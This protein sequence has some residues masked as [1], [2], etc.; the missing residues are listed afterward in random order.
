M[1]RKWILLAAAIAFLAGCSDNKE[2]VNEHE[3]KQIND[4]SKEEKEVFPY[5]APLTGIGFKE[6]P[7]GRAYAVMINNDPKARP[8]SGLHKADIV[9]ELLAEGNVTR[10][11]AVFQSEEADRI[12][13]VRS[14]RDY[15]IELAK[16]YDAL[17]IAH[18]YSPE[19]KKMLDKGYIDHIN[20][21]QYD[22]S[23]FKRDKSRV[24]PHNS[25]IT[26]EAVLK[27]ADKIGIDMDNTPSTL[28]FLSEKEAEE[29]DGEQANSVLISY[30][31]SNLF[32]VI[33]EYDEGT[34]KYKRYSNDELTADL[35]S[36]EPVLLD[37]IF[38]VETHHEIIDSEGR[39]KIDLTSGGS[40]YLLQ[41]G[42][43]KEVEWKNVEG[44]I[45]PFL[46]DQEVGLVPGKTWINI[47]PSKEGLENIVSFDVQ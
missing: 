27:G 32:N 18:G 33:F 12:G 35:D 9:Y 19:A 43:W 4:V 40:A 25:Y 41:R 17:Y 39:R 47:V 21:M 28:T 6:E 24:A 11:L 46:N 5:Q 23:L 45:L 22:G 1:S 16:G 10:F 26:S 8:Q 30:F 14:A 37:N 42:K 7:E 13:P 31:S 15:Y 44:K 36:S 3:E 29:L 20:G 2:T 34:K 38:I